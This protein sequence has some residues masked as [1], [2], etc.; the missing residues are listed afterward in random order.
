M[1][2]FFNKIR[3]VFNLFLIMLLI[4]AAAAV[5]VYFLTTP[6]Q[7][8]TTFWIS[9]GFLGFALVLETLMA[10]GIAMR[11][12]KGK[13]VPVGFSKVILGGLYFVFVI[14]V[15]IWNAFKGFSTTAYILIHVGGLVVFL[16]PMIM[17]NMASLRMSGADRKERE[18]GR[19]NLSSLAN[20]VAYV[21]DDMKANRWETGNAG[22]MDQADIM[23]VANLA[24]ALRYSDPA[25][26]SSKIERELDLAVQRL[27]VAAESKNP[28]D[29]SR[30]CLEAERAL[31]DRN[32]FVINNK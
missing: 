11:S 10:S 8:G 24:E 19:L 26:A 16:I 28:E 32:D 20:K 21:A 25:P 15:S 29:I 22:G 14:A 13:E 17:M 18:E 12:N 5:F 23:R 6:E 3:Q 9:V 2:K 27:V 1:G 7:R 4:A 30:A 31:K